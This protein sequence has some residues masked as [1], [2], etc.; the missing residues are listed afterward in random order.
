M[1]LKE[2]ANLA[3]VSVSTASRALAG[4]RQLSDE[5]I[6]HVRRVA[7]EHGYYTQ[8]MARRRENLKNKNAEIAI[9][10][11][12]IT[13]SYYS[14]ITTVL[15][16][17]LGEYGCGGSVHVC[18]FDKQSVEAFAYTLM[19]QCAADG[20]ISLTS[21]YLHEDKPALPMVFLCDDSFRSD[22]PAVY[23]DMSGGMRLLAE[24]LAEL[25]HRRI[26]FIGETR[27]MGKY[28]AFCE[29]MQAVG[30]SVEPG[31]IYIVDERFEKI[32]YEA[33]GRLLS[34]QGIPDAF[35]CA[36]DEIALGAMHA[37][38]MNGLSVPEDLSVVGINDIPAAEYAGV[39]L[40]TL[41]E[42]KEDLCRKAAEILHRQL[43]DPGSVPKE[44]VALPFTLVERASVRDRRK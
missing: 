13:S 39:P 30:L 44:R 23:S 21:F 42:H 7:K 10:V 38:K 37:L 26:G 25:G 4:S 11:P 20:I 40:T 29:A 36:Y 18:G 28:A 17:V 31:D 9:L 34:G 19:S 43:T 2:L 22:C 33:V 12:E 5:T 41:R 6:S 8:K 15:I 35:V 32:G 24:K 27:T 14:E 16:G 3:H 1:T